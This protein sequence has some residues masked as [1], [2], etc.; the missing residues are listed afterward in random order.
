MENGGFKMADNMNMKLNDEMMEKA[1]GG[2]DEEKG[3]K[4]HAIVRG[5]HEHPYYKDMIE[6][7]L[8]GGQDVI[9]H[10]DAINVINPGTEVIVELVGL[11][12]WKIIEIL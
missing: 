5:I 6:V 11:G 7:T 9:A 1:T 12:R 3:R 8:D 4:R 2:D 10:Y